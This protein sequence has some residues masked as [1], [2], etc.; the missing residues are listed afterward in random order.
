[1]E[2]EEAQDVRAGRIVEVQYYCSSTSSSTEVESSTE[3]P[4]YC[5]DVTTGRFKAGQTVYSYVT[6]ENTDVRRGTYYIEFSV[7]DEK[8]SKW[9]GQEKRA[10]LKPNEKHAYA[11]GWTVPDDAPIGEYMGFVVL[12][13]EKTEYSTKGIVATKS[14]L[15]SRTK[16]DAFGIIPSQDSYFIARVVDK[17]NEPI[18]PPVSLS[19]I[20]RFG[21]L[22]IKS[23]TLSLA[24]LPERFTVSWVPPNSKEGV[25]VEIIALK[26]GH[27][28]SEAFVYTV[29]RNSPSSGELF[30]HTFVLEKEQMVKKEEPIKK[31]E[32]QTFFEK[33]YYDD[34]EYIAGI[35]TTSNVQ[36]VTLDQSL[37]RMIFSIEELRSK[38]S[39]NITMPKTLIEGPFTVN[40]SGVKFTQNSTHSS[41]YLTYDRGAQTI[42]ITGS[43]V[44]PEFPLTGIV[45]I[46]SISMVVVF[47]ILMRRKDPLTSL[48]FG[49]SFFT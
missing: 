36:A 4:S 28:Q 7:A 3:P 15:D 27:K 46:A 16:P 8:G 47:G 31:I 19:V 45:I 18:E 40:K 24:T 23:Y 12:Y 49:R 34:K 33:I 22:I 9:F 5:S 37:K 42:E 25:T 32:P 1:V 30:D 11:L 35:V 38:G 13:G 29:S 26:D 48:T 41:I 14:R 10:P 17:S 20:E 39:A 6:I 43:S 2:K 21:A 44:V